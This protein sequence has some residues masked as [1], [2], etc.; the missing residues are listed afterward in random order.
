MGVKAMAHVLNSAVFE[1]DQA[2]VKEISKVKVTLASDGKVHIH[3]MVT[4]EAMAQDIFHCLIK[5][6]YEGMKVIPKHNGVLSVDDRL[7]TERLVS[8]LR[9]LSAHQL[10]SDSLLSNICRHFP[11]LSKGMSCSLIQ[12][13]GAIISNHDFF[14]AGNANIM[15][16]KIGKRALLQKLM[17]SNN[18][19]EL[20]TNANFVVL[21]MVYKPLTG[22]P[23]AGMRFTR[24]L[25]LTK[26]D[27]EKMSERNK[28]VETSESL[29]TSLIFNGL[30]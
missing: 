5:P 14:C 9:R 29:S 16:R 25:N 6:G 12:D 13:S 24:P 26:A 28:S 21:D 22:L 17:D 19:E 1:D 4:N 27:F 3:F 23:N 30:K 11:T 20:N 15:E 18:L 7:D 8:K 2:Q 10:L